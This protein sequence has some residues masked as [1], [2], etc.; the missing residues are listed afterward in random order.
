MVA[1][2]AAVATKEV[3]GFSL[4]K[5]DALCKVTTDIKT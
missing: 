3:I 5:T 2:F 4:V 1:A